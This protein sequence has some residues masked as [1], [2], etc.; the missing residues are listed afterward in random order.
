MIIYFLNYCVKLVYRNLVENKF[1]YII[2][3]KGNYLYNCLITFK[4][5]SSLNLDEI[6]IIGNY[7]MYKDDVIIFQQS[8]LSKDMD[9]QIIRLYSNHFAKLISI[10]SKWVKYLYSE[11]VFI[12]FCDVFNSINHN[13]CSLTFGDYF[14]T[15]FLLEPYIKNQFEEEEEEINLLSK[16][17]NNHL[18]LD[19]KINFKIALKNKIE[20]KNLYLSVYLLQ[21]IQ[22]DKLAT[23]YLIESEF[24]KITRIMNT[25]EKINFQDQEIRRQIERHLELNKSDT[26]SSVGGK[27]TTS[28]YGGLG[29]F[30][31]NIQDKNNSNFKVDNILIKFRQFNYLV[32]FILIFLCFLF[33]GKGIQNHKAMPKLDNILTNFYEIEKKFYKINF[34]NFLKLNV[35]VN[36]ENLFDNYFVNQTNVNH[37]ISLKDI[38]NFFNSLEIDTLRNIT[39]NFFY[40]INDYENSELLNIFDKK[41][42]FYNLHISETIFIDYKELTF[43]EAISLFFA[44]SKNLFNEDDIYVDVIK[45]TVDFFDF[46]NIQNKNLNRAQISVYQLILNLKNYNYFID[47]AKNSIHLIYNSRM[48]LIFLNNVHFFLSLLAVHF[49]ILINSFSILNFFKKKIIEKN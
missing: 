10:P 22:H 24:I 30:N 37:T 45:I 33:I 9:K 39:N 48:D 17:I 25:N 12:K 14:K 38:N 8:K 2:R 35:H 19:T 46:S 29:I 42:N 7:E 40:L 16:N 26:S 3:C 27:S 44:F 20:H 36:G 28:Y 11:K 5:F 4:T 18:N 43:S 13:K 6:I 47:Y 15:Y 21:I 34:S 41:I 32:Y 1:E 31:K 49:I 23:T